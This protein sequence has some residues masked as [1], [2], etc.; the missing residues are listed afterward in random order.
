M[1][2]QVAVITGASRNIGREIALDLARQGCDIVVAGGSNLGAVQSVMS[3]IVAIGRRAVPFIGDLSDSANATALVA[4]ATEALGR[5][6]I[7]VCNA[8]IRRKKCFVEITLNEWHEVMNA[9]LNAPFYCLRAAVPIMLEQNYGRVITIG[10]SSGFR[11]TPNRSHVIA[12]KMGLLSLTRSIAI[13]YGEKN[14]TANCVAPGHMDTT[15][16]AGVPE[17]SQGMTERPIERLGTVQEIAAMV[18][19]LCRPE[20]SYITGQCI[21]VNGGMYMGG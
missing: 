2:G 10:G 3:E 11:L 21:H 7:L 13:E 5:L 8:A 1:Y 12:A 6:D 16:G 18:S 20:A 4:M 15:R 9:D 14:I 19:Y 17:R